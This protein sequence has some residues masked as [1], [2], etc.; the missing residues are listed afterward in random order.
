[1]QEI[2]KCDIAINRNSR[3]ENGKQN[4]K[5]IYSVLIN[6]ISTDEDRISE[7]EDKLEQTLV[8]R[9]K[10]EKNIQEGKRFKD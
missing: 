7:M 4:K 1:M 8:Q 6:R 2:I 5:S 3:Y 9:E 10:H